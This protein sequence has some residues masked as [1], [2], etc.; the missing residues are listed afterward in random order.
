MVEDGTGR[1]RKLKEGAIAVSY[2]DFPL[3]TPHSSRLRA[4]LGSRGE[5]DLP[6]S[7]ALAE[8]I[9]L[10]VEADYGVIWLPG[11]GSGRLSR[12]RGAAG[13][14]DHLGATVFGN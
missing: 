4:L 14:C 6:R 13:F 10:P 1:E 7:A 8:R 5:A 11:Q 2:V 12:F 3:R 9:G